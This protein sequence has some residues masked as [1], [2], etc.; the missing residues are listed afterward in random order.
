MEFSSFY[1]LNMIENE[2]RLWKRK[3]RSKYL[4]WWNYLCEFSVSAMV[5][6]EDWVQRLNFC[7]N[8]HSAVINSLTRFPP[9]PFGENSF[10]EYGPLSPFPVNANTVKR[11]KELWSSE[12]SRDYCSLLVSLEL[13]SSQ[14]AQWTTVH[15]GQISCE[16]SESWVSPWTPIHY[17]ILLS[18]G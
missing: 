2:V 13:K 18:S 15:A 8:S 6:L 5:Q 11:I 16:Q 9:V 17:G 10:W 12:I 7:K 1:N 4:L 3:H 14:E